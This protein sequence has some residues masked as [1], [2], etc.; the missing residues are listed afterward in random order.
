MKKAVNAIYNLEN[1]SPDKFRYWEK[2][3]WK[4]NMEDIFHKNY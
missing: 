3:L 2:Y 1:N 4:P